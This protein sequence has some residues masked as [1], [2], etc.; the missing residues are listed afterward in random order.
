MRARVLEAAQ[1]EVEPGER[2]ADA[3][4][5]LRR[6]LADV[7]E[8]RPVEVGDQPRPAGAG[9]AVDRHEI[10]ALA[11]ANDLRHEPRDGRVGE[12]TE[13]PDLALD[14]STVRPAGRD[15]EHPAFTGSGDEDEVAVDLAGQGLGPRLEAPALARDALGIPGTEARSGSA[16]GCSATVGA[17]VATRYVILKFYRAAARKTRGPGGRAGHGLRAAA[18]PSIVAS[19][20][21]TAFSSCWSRP[22][23]SRAGSLSTSTSGSR[24]LFSMS[25]P[26]LSR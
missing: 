24:C 16:H 11:V 4:E 14:G 1:G 5:E 13:G 8:R 9:R 7:D 12:E 26:S 17:G 18:Q 15:L 6:A 2:A 20:I 21:S 19:R 22:A 3:L 25:S 23:A 10:E